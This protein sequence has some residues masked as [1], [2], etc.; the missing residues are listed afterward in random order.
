MAQA[1]ALLEGQSELQGFSMLDDA[2]SD[3]AMARNQFEESRRLAISSYER[4]EA[5]DST[6]RTRAGRLSIWLRDAESVAQI[7]EDHRQ[8]PGA[9]A[10]IS[11]LELQAGLAA[12]EGR[13][14]EAINLFR[15]A[16]AIWR[17]R[18]IRFELA[19][20][21]LTMVHA[22]GTN[23]PEVREAAAE[24]REIF[25]QL[26]AT[27]LLALLDAA[28]AGTPRPPKASPSAAEVASRVSSAHS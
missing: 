22:L 19:L 8:V 26:G 3:A 23:H 6:S 20:A 18:G 4:V 15:E 12:L 25:T 10:R 17:E 5:P 1:A 2:R 24:A 9:I 11:E 16:L 28:E 14:R 7:L 13:S 21:G 27:P